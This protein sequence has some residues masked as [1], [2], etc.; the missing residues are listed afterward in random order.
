M[1]IEDQ[2]DRFHYLNE[3]MG[4]MQE[5]DELYDSLTPSREGDDEYGQLID[6][7]GRM[8]KEH[9]ELDLEWLE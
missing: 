2:D 9:R 1:K 3:L 8:L 4:Y 5:I 7:A 6:I